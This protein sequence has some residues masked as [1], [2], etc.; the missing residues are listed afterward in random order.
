MALGALAAVVALLVQL[1]LTVNG[2]L[3]VDLIAREAARAASRS[4]DPSNA[5]HRLVAELDEQATVDVEITG[6]I[7]TVTIQRP[8]PVIARISGR[9]SLIGRSA[10]ALEPP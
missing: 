7:V 5:A 3:E 2:Q 9:P 1:L 8:A 10:M 6:V 4:A